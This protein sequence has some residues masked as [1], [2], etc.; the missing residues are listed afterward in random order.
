MPIPDRFI[1]PTAERIEREG[2]I[3]LPAADELLATTPAH[4][5]YGASPRH[6]PARQPVDDH[7]LPPLLIAPEPEWSGYLD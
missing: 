1:D 3:P 7:A 2:P 5:D 6:R 4:G